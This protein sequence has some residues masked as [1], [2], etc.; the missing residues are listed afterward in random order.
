MKQCSKC[1]EIKDESCFYFRKSMGRFYPSCKACELAAMKVLRD[2]KRLDPNWVLV[3]RARMR[4]MYAMGTKR[5]PVVSTEKRTEYNRRHRE[6]HRA[7]HLARNKVHAAIRY[8]KIKALP[9]E[10][11]GASP[12]QAHHEDYSKPLD[13]RWLCPKH[14]AERHVEIRNLQLAS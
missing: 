7:K 10:V 5:K 1:K 11:C 8:G 14:H 2:D 4:S 9:C 13:V 3:E 6:K 12:A